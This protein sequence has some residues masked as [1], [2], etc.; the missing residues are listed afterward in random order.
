[1][2]LRDIAFLRLRGQ[3]LTGLSFP[4]INKMVSH[5]GALQ[6]QDYLAAK[7]SIGVRL[8]SAT[9]EDVEK[10]I[11]KKKIVRTWSFR[12][13]LHFMGPADVRWMLKLAAPRL[14]SAHAGLYRKQELDEAAIAKSMQVIRNMLEGENRATRKEIQE[15]LAQTGIPAQGLRGNLI[16]L[17]AS[18]EGLI[19]H[20]P[21][22]NKEFTFVLL[23]EWLPR[24]KIIEG[25]KALAEIACRFVKSHGPVTVKDLSGWC[26][27]TVTDAKH[28]LIM[29]EKHLA[30]RSIEGQEYWME[31]NIRPAS[32]SS[33]VHL[34][35]AF[36]EYLM[37][38]KDRSA[39][40]DEQ[41]VNKVMG[42][43]NG[44]VSPTI[45]IDGKVEGTWK[46]TVKKDKVMIE[47][48]CFR[49]QSKAIK[50]GIE[51]A[52]HG[53]ASFLGLAAAVAHQ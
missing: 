11:E 30:P 10:A 46:R 2:T 3:Q 33:R 5:L 26:G 19:C 25:D 13:T 4:G 21:R 36:D 48:H 17:R 7:W 16:F 50:N 37:G 1:M 6:A 34:L 49:Q 52:A 28:A 18:L 9:D 31:N 20:G 39:L 14:I 53:Y 44:Q 22:H 24:A 41:H 43:G 38:Y 45:I 23:D 8:P 29:N 32:L 51:E 35:P 42:V 12:G 15:T 47:T 27:I 40:L